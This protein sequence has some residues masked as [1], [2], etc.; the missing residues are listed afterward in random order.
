MIRFLLLQ[1]RQGKT[2]LSKWWVPYEDN[3][4]HQ[5]AIEARLLNA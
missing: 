5:I 4:K 2:R 3:E 1:N